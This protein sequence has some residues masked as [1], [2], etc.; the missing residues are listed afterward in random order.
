MRP[1]NKHLTPYVSQITP[2]DVKIIKTMTSEK[3]DI[4]DIFVALK[5]KNPLRKDPTLY[6]WIEQVNLGKF[7]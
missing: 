6:R 1:Q 4:L 2:E 5:V 3:A 7:D